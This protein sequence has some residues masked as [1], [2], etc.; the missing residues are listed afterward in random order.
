MK[1][2]AFMLVLSIILFG[3]QTNDEGNSAKTDN[4]LLKEWEG[5]YQGVPAF[6][7]MKVE[8]LEPAMD[9]AMATHL[10]EIDEI[11]EN[12]DPATFEN[13][14]E[15]FERS[16]K[17]LTVS[18]PIMVFGV[19]T[20]HHQSLEKFSKNCLPKFQNT[21]QKSIRMKNCSNGLKPFM[22]TVKKNR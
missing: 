22:T 10:E 12:P 13:T 4:P 6:D 21:V 20:I 8:D 15:A 5:P 3:C 19:V 16:G 2:I 11:T 9:D 1:K 14:I 17:P 18:L 7:Q